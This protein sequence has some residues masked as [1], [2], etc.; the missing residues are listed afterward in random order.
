M[1][2]KVDGTPQNWRDF[3]PF[4]NGK[5]LGIGQEPK[6]LSKWKSIVSNE[7]RLNKRKIIH[8]ST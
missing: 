1:E 5:K 7:I 8:E 4:R 6:C 2:Y 3:P